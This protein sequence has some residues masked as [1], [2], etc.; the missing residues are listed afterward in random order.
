MKR[1]FENVVLTDFNTLRL[2][3]ID[4]TEVDVLLDGLQEKINK[5]SLL[6]ELGKGFDSEINLNNAAF[7]IEKLEFK[8]NIVYGDIYFLDNEK[9]GEALNFYMQNDNPVEFKL[10]A[11][12]SDFKIVSIITWD[13]DFKYE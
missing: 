8:D 3:D 4:I 10:R 2:Q 12:I 11:F 9:G 13:L 6:G 7:E 5:H 1:K